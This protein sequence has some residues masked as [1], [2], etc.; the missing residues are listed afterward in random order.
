MH[1]HMNE[2]Q[3]SVRTI[4]LE[5]FIILLHSNIPFSRKMSK[6]FKILVNAEPHYQT[7]LGNEANRGSGQR[8]SKPFIYNS[9]ITEQ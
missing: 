9:T 2:G 5:N 4:L 1:N 3:S 7:F 8:K 6:K